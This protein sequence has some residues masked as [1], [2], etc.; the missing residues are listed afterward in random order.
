MEKN[1]RKITEEQLISILSDMYLG[2]VI[3]FTD[4][5]NMQISQTVK[6]MLDNQ[7]RMQP[8]YAN[9]YNKM[10][11][12]IDNFY[13]LMNNPEVRKKIIDTKM[14]KTTFISVY[15]TDIL[16]GTERM[17]NI[18]HLLNTDLVGEYK[19]DARK[20]IDHIHK[21]GVDNIYFYNGMQTIIRNI[22]LL[23]YDHWNSVKSTIAEYEI[24]RRT[25]N[26]SK[27]YKVFSNILISKMEEEAYR[28]AVLDQLLGEE[29]INVNSLKGYI[30]E[31]VENNESNSGEIKQ[32]HSYSF[33]VNNNLYIEYDATDLSAVYEFNRQKEKRVVEWGR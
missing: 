21:N 2:K 27:S 19:G 17:Y 3:R 30:G 11:N 22:G 14:N 8:E 13:N 31:V 25:I 12:I 29:N 9:E 32:P 26:K 16:G 4:E 7:I 10:Y 18:L 5:K 23:S 20:K 6:R 28:N 24:I 1:N 15:R 33:R